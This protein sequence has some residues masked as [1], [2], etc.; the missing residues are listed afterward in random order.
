MY[1]LKIRPSLDDKFKKL[2]QKDK[3]QMEIIS[4][5]INEILE[6]P[7]YYKNLRSPLQHLKR[8]HIGKSYVLVFSVDE[9]TKTVTLED[10]DHHDIIYK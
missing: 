9:N 5:K 8:T 6:N 4:R 7:Q 3:K 2:S 10:Y 1:A